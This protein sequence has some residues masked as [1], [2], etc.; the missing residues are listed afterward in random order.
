MVS[1]GP[2][3]LIEMRSSSLSGDGKQKQQE[4]Y[5]HSPEDGSNE[6]LS[7]S[8]PRV[9]SIEPQ[10]PALTLISGQVERVHGPLRSQA[11]RSSR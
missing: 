6:W 3:W 11:E 9:E 8:T 7:V 2:C 4:N 5:H 1:R 10:S